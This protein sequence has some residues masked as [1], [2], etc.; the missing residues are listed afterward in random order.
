MVYL[1]NTEHVEYIKLVIKNIFINLIDYELD[2]IQ[3][4]TITIIDIL[5]CKFNYSKKTINEFFIQITLNRNSDII[6]I[7][8]LIL[9][10]IDDRNNFELYK[11]IYRLKDITCKKKTDI[12]LNDK[13]INP[14]LICN[15]QYSRYFDKD[16]LNNQIQKFDPKNNDSYNEYLYTIYDLEISFKLVLETIEQINSKLYINWINILPIAI[17]NYQESKKYKNSFDY[18]ENENKFLF[19][20]DNDEHEFNFWNLDV[21]NPLAIYG[22]I[23]AKDVFNT[24]YVYLF[25][26]IFT[27]GTKWLLYENQENPRDMPIMYIEIFNYI[28]DI[29]L[30]IEGKNYD[31]IE[32]VIIKDSIVKWNNLFTKNE[33]FIKCVIFKFDQRFCND[34][35]SKEYNYDYKTLYDKIKKKDEEKDDEDEF[36]DFDQL[37]PD[38]NLY[39]EYLEKVKNFKDNIPFQVIYN[40][41]IDMVNKFKKTWYGI[42]IL[43]YDNKKYIIN[44]NFNVNNKKIDNIPTNNNILYITYK[45]IYNYAKSICLQINKNKIITDARCLN[46]TTKKKFM[47]LL[48]NNDKFNIKNVIK[49]TYGSI[50]KI[51]IDKYQKLISKFFKENL[52]NIV[53]E[54]YIQLGLL[55]EFVSDSELTDEN[56][57]GTDEIIKR[58]NLKRNL[59]K[60]FNKNEENKNIY[61]ETYYYLTRQ[62]Y[63]QLELYD[64]KTLKELNWFEYT[65]EIADYLSFALNWV[66]QINFYHHFINNRVIYVTGA[67]GQGKSV[68]VPKLLY[69]AVIAINLNSSSRVISTQ[70]TVAPT[71]SNADKLSQDL[72]VPIILNNFETFSSFVQYSTQSDKHLVSNSDTF[73][74]EVTDR[75]LYEEITK[76]PYLKKQK[77]K[78]YT[79]DNLYDVIIIDEAHM[80]NVNMD[81]ILTFMRNYLYI[82]NQV[83]LIITSATM[84]DDEFIYRRYYRILD[85]NYG[86][87]I[88]PIFANLE[89]IGSYFLNLN[90][91][92]ILDKV[93]VD[94]RYHI[95]PPGQTTKF[96]V[97]DIYL[98]Y[99]PENYE[100]AEI[101]GLNILK[102]IM[103]KNN[104][105]DVLFFTITEKILLELVEKINMDSPSYVIAL[106]LFS[107]LR[108]KPGQWFD[109]IQNIDK[110]KHLLT[111]SKA[112]MLNVILNGP[113][114][115]K[116]IQS[117]LYSMIVIVATNVVEASVT[118]RSL[119][120]VIDTGYFN[121]VVFD[122]NIN[123]MVI[124][125]DPI[126]EA[127]RLQRRGRTGRVGSGTVYYTYKYKSRAHIKPRY[128]IVTSDITF[129]LYNILHD[130]SGDEE[131]DRLYNPE[132]HPC[133]YNKNGKLKFKDYINQEPNKIV[134]NIY[135]QQYNIEEY[136][137]I[138]NLNCNPFNQKIRILNPGY[139]NGYNLSTLI[140]QDGMF[141][142]IH[143]S[144]EN[145]KRDVITGNIIYD[146]KENKKIDKYISKKIINSMTKLQNIK[147]IY[148]DKIIKNP[149]KEYMY[150]HK[151][152]YHTIIDKIN[153]NESE[154][155]GFL[156]KT[157]SLEEIVKIIKTICISVCYN[158]TDDILKILSLIYSIES[159]KKFVKLQ[160]NGKFNEYEK[161]LDKWKNNSELLS[162]LNMMNFFIKK[163]NNKEDE[164]IIDRFDKV[165]KDYNDFLELEKK[166]SSKI[167]IKND[168][169]TKISKDNIK[170]FI[171][172]KNQNFDK[173]KRLKEFNNKK[174][175]KN[176]DNNMNINYYCD[177][178]VLNPQT[179]INALKT[180]KTF[181]NIYNNN[182]KEIDEFKKFY[183][184][185]RGDHEENILK[186]FLENFLNNL[187]IYKKNQ[188][189]N[190]IT[191]NIIKIPNI[192]LTIIVNLFFYIRMTKDGPIGI[193]NLSKKIINDVISDKV[194]NL[195]KIYI[196][197]KTHNILQTSNK[198][199]LNYPKSEYSMNDYIKK[200]IT[201]IKNI[202]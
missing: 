4:F 40:F 96:I 176:V 27:S 124:S 166:Y 190:I 200:T 56:I 100:Q 151:F 117:N 20:I 104:T 16:V 103:A 88:C 34:E 26:E 72:G 58:K 119:K 85:D 6:S 194:I 187:C 83:K 22:G 48:V 101:Q 143:P 107:K 42:Q 192:C 45:N 156:M 67:T 79:N 49:K 94:R 87:P 46:E 201:M 188:I 168:L 154:N 11:Q 169:I 165:E 145:F 153:Q 8:Y 105:G 115:Y 93:V 29:N 17:V 44:K 66:S 175:E 155:L 135:Q 126:P 39:D 99:D 61:L 133:N 138:T 81:L 130:F 184:V 146:N 161:F 172:Y 141:Y 28:I 78:E 51:S 7:M 189:T 181:S 24:I 63:S 199:L 178:L 12:D 18:N 1:L 167:F 37:K 33:I 173:N 62:T 91:N 59:L 52:K 57:L 41:L 193:S 60:K 149:E 55:N 122:E 134:K 129:D 150:I 31:L 14:Y 71:Q 114:N 159:Y 198:Y 86:F 109:K 171:K 43:K 65:F 142:I 97:K 186:T 136:E 32:S 80:H 9:P 10:Y 179:I 77:G 180:Y 147:Y 163:I 35:I 25:N 2:A 113:E 162:Y 183:P 21:E 195:S 68:I 182:N 90:D 185:I 137:F 74:K 54:T 23:T 30:I 196:K 53:F 111:Y 69:Y 118:I 116:K 5:A 127:S 177:F 13:S 3:I 95:S 70:P 47:E 110:N 132:C 170:S 131:K 120:F 75:T 121:S 158:C 197:D 128:G 89:I 64:P 84:D 112:D 144:E 191:D 36:L 164:K 15:Y 160:D 108:D 76:N 125:I 50:D 92:V 19:K 123:D 152:K 202:N 38:G 157:S 73:I 98:D 82:N 140:D 106:P 174:Y 102:N 139:T 148:F